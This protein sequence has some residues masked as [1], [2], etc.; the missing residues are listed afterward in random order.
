MCIY[1]YIYIYIYRERER[2]RYVYIYI[3]IHI[4][5]NMIHLIIN[6]IIKWGLESPAGAGRRFFMRVSFANPPHKFWVS[7][8][9]SPNQP[10]RPCC[11]APF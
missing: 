10:P 1:I 4:D 2:E 5:T 11:Y 3:Y 8:T 6:V 7:F 9:K